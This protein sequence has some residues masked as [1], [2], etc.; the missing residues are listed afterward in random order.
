MSRFRIDCPECD[1]VVDLIDEGM[2]DY[3]CPTCKRIYSDEDGVQD[4][5]LAEDMYKLYKGAK[6]AGL[7]PDKEEHYHG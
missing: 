4:L 2:G 1:A 3:R 6:L 7:I 5:D